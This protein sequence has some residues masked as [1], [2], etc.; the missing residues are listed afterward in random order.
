MDFFFSW[1]DVGLRYD[2]LTQCIENLTL[3][4][5]MIDSIWV[6]NVCFVNSKKTEIHVSPTHNIF[7]L[8]YPTGT[9]WV[10]YRVS[11]GSCSKFQ[12][13]QSLWFQ[14][15]VEAPCDVVSYLKPRWY[16]ILAI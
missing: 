1:T 10:N 15:K 11:S 7:L 9:V 13:W 12:K 6:P 4:H 2:H 14:V 16:K 5:H 3:S 8:I